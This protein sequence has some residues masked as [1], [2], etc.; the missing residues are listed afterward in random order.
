MLQ[1]TDE[2]VGLDDAGNPI[3]SLDMTA[4]LE[5]VQATALVPCLDKPTSLRKVIPA[6]CVFTCYYI[7]ACTISCI[8]CLAEFERLLLQVI[9]RELM[10]NVLEGASAASLEH[11]ASLATPACV[12]V[13]NSTRWSLL[14]ILGAVPFPSACAVL[15][16]QP[17]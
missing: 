3:F 10:A 13:S 17:V 4:L 14:L 16:H 12:R 8:K 9:N 7:P 15:N 6:E 1:A 11:S 2:L 5:N